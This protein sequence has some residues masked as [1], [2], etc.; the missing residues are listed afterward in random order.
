[1]YGDLGKDWRATA[2]VAGPIAF[3]G[4]GRTGPTTFAAS[5]DADGRYQAIKALAVVD[6]GAEVV[7]SIADRDRAH[8]ALLYDPASFR[9]DGRYALADGEPAVDFRSCPKG[10]QPV[11]PDGPT[12]FNGGFIVDGPRCITVEVSNVHTG[13]QTVSKIAFGRGT[14]AARD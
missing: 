8:S 11:G 2:L 13:R 12:Q 1:V 10:G 5:P 3:L 14:C 7:V 9:D 6:E 4:F